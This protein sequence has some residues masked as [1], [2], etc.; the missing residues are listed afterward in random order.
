MRVPDNYDLCEAHERDQEKQ[1]ERLPVCDSCD[2]PIQDDYVFEIEGS[3]LCWECLKR[4]Y[5]KPIEDFI[6]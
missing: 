6:F 1:L 2:Q 5:R 3:V 4:D